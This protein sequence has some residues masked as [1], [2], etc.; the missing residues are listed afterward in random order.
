M[1]PVL[2][3]GGASGGGDAQVAGTVIS[4]ISALLEFEGSR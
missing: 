3:S 1:A 2:T 4:R